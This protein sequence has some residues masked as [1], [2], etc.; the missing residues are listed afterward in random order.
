[1][2]ALDDGLKSGYTRSHAT[3]VD[4]G[5]EFPGCGDKKSGAVEGKMSSKSGVRK[6]SSG[7]ESLR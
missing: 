3:K 5:L 7:R 4:L 6:K 2:K 1:M